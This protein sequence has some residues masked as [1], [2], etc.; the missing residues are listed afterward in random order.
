M[1]DGP[2]G[3]PDCPVQSRFFPTPAPR[4]V[5]NA[6][7][8]RTPRLDES[9]HASTPPARLVS[10]RELS[11]LENKALI[12]RHN[13][14]GDSTFKLGLTPFADVSPE[15]FVSEQLTYTP[16]KSVRD[17]VAHRRSEALGHAAAAA[18]G[19]RV[20]QVSRGGV[21]GE[22]SRKMLLGAAAEARLGAKYPRNFN[23][24]DV[25]E[26]MG[27]I[28]TQE[29]SC[30]SCWA[31]TSTDT[32]EAIEVI[33]GRR[34]KH[35]ELSAEQLI[36]CDNYDSGC[37]TGNMFTAYEWIHEHGGLATARAFHGAAGLLARAESAAMLSAGSGAALGSFQD[38]TAVRKKDAKALFDQAQHAGNLGE[39][40]VFFE[41]SLGAEEEKR[42]LD[43]IESGLGSTHGNCPANMNLQDRVYGY[44]E[45]DFDAGEAA[46]MEAV[47]KQPVAVGINANK[48]FQLYA[49]GIIRSSDCGPAP[50]TPD[51]EI[52]AINHA[53]VVV[54]WGEEVVKG[55]TIKYWVLKNSFGE[56][57]GERGYF[58]LERGPDTVDQEGFGTCGLYFESVYPVIDEDANEDSCIEGSTFRSKYYSAAYAGAGLGKPSTLNLRDLTSTNASTGVG[59]VAVM[60]VGFG[61][62]TGV[63]VV[64]VFMAARAARK[65]LTRGTEEEP[66]L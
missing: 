35:V 58:K 66:L 63:L 16:A 28:H 52:M 54:G 24:A 3:P 25:P 17:F 46:L 37:N 32:I 19:V 65:Q 40:G 33:S 2:R 64:S 55:E 21:V 9:T 38:V 60:L 4:P 1:S 62:V 13:A 27:K 29:T 61:F 18:D 42:V 11:F 36:N 49:S 10:R 56:N 12:E 14:Q 43:S 41:E 48:I 47:S 23:W 34:R 5:L 51:S 31:Y 6:H 39:F 8:R 22:V 53:V 57:W 30:A 26:V 20:G 15:E 59:Q 45:L 44:C 7:P 50:H